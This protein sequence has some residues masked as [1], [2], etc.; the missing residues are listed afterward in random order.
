M[1]VKGAY[2][3]VLALIFGNTARRDVCNCLHMC[4]MI[5]VYFVRHVAA[6]HSGAVA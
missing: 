5:A 2:R 3:C 1:D 4:Y 6:S